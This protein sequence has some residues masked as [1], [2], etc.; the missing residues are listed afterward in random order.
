M[1][2]ANFIARE[3][4]LEAYISKQYRPSRFK[5]KDSTKVLLKRINLPVGF[6]SRFFPL[7]K[8]VK[9]LAILS[10]RNVNWKMFASARG[11]SV[12]SW[13]P[14]TMCILRISRA[15][16]SL[17]TMVIEG[18]SGKSTININKAMFTL[19]AWGAWAQCRVRFSLSTNVNKLFFQT[20]TP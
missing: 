1:F 11:L 2:Q 20:A 10:S 9:A 19:S 5:I 8:Q 3:E 15:F 16:F 14:K 18:E 13:S 7:T 4:K 17:M 12:G 6:I